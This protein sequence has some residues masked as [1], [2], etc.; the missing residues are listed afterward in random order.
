MDIEKYVELCAP[1]EFR[2]LQ[3]LVQER[4][5]REKHP[6]VPGKHGLTPSEC[7]DLRTGDKL[8]VIRLVK[9]RTGSSMMEAKDL[10][11]AAGPMRPTSAREWT[12]LLMD[13]LKAW[14]NAPEVAAR[15]GLKEH[16]QGLC[17]L[18][19]YATTDGE[20]G[21]KNSEVDLFDA[22]LPALKALEVDS[23]AERHTEAMARC[24]ELLTC[25]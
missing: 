11:E 25:L 18:Q 15:E 9:L 1:G 14:K 17:W 8:R 7:R 10:V 2:E 23:T 4:V 20:Y 5:E 24:L 19:E 22:L 16:Y 3:R 21:V 6:E 12:E 13:T